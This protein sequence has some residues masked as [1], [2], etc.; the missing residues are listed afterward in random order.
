MARGSGRSRGRRTD[1][2]WAGVGDI[3]A[4]LDIGAVAS[5]MGNSSQFTGAGTIMR[6]RGLVGA[7]L[8][9]GAV[10]ESG[11]VLCGLVV[12]SNDAKVAGAAPEFTVSGADA[13]EGH[14]LW[15]GSIYLS[16]GLEAAIV[17]D[18]LSS[19][20]EVDSKAMRRVKPNDVLAMVVE[21]P[22]ALW[23]DQ[24]GTISITARWRL[25]IGS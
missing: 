13:E 20:V 18:Q 3:I 9:A 24:A 19:T 1:Y 6:V 25:L 14:W 21:A 11:I 7:T 15:T 2:S 12:V 10:S 4:A 17:N 5:F 22:S 8:N 16:S 23:T